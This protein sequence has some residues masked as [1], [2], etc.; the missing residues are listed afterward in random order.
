[1]IILEQLQSAKFNLKYTGMSYYDNF[2]DTKNLEYMRSHKNRTGEIV[3]MTPE[4]Y[5]YRCAEDIF[6]VTVDYLK[7]SRKYRADKIEKYK[8]DMLNGDV[9]PLC[10]LNYADK[11]QEGLHRMLAAGE[12][13][14]WD[15]EYPVLVVSVYDE[16]LEELDKARYDLESYFKWK[17]SDDIKKVRDII[18][19]KYNAYKD[20]PPANVTQILQKE[21]YDL[22]DGKLKARV[23]VD[24]DDLGEGFLYPTTVHFE[25]VIYRGLQ[26]SDYIDPNYYTKNYYLFLEDM[27]NLP[28]DFEE[29]DPTDLLFDDAEIDNF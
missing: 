10:M 21:L 4:E 29:I 8:E 9:F 28:T 3:Y 22:T 23:Y 5:Y 18:N 26:V 15:I 20:P 27:F 24:Y 13:F 25:P 16:E 11:G 1:M 19:S 14:G 6:G 7:D 17:F 12:A 2:L